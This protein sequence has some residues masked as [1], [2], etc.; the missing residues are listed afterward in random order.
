MKDTALEIFTLK[1]KTQHKDLGNGKGYEFNSMA[2]TH[3]IQ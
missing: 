2:L 3:S 1:Q